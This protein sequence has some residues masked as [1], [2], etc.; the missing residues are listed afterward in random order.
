VYDRSIGTESLSKSR[1]IQVYLERN[2]KNILAVSGKNCST[3]RICF[4]TQEI[5]F[6]MTLHRNTFDKKKV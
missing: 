1:V 2:F 3:Q 4:D 5:P 6:H